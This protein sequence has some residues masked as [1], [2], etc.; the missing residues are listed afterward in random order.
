M[1]PDGMY[2]RVL[3]EVA[4][5]VVKPLSIIFAKSWQSAQSPVTG[6]KGNIA[7]IFKKGIKGEP[8]NYSL[9]STTLC[10]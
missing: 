4:G 1:G 6:K 7:P 2:P 8:E 10:A 9:V 5:V 3:R